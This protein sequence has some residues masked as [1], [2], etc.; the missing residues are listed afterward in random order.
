MP[1]A[2]FV[3]PMRVSGEAVIRFVSRNRHA[4]ETCITHIRSAYCAAVGFQEAAGQCASCF[5]FV[6]FMVIAMLFVAMLFFESAK[7]AGLSKARNVVIVGIAVESVSMESKLSGTTIYASC[8][9]AAIGIVCT[10]DFESRR[11]FFR[12][13]VWN[14]VG[15]NIHDASRGTAAVNQRAW[16]HVHLDTL[17]DERFDCGGMIRAADGYIQGVDTVF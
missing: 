5:L 9:C 3:M 14:S 4:K 13:G 2:L 8:G 11:C 17:C 6:S 15:V 16:P 7:S 12:H 10:T 1:F